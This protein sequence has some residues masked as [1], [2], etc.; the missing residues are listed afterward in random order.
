MLKKYLIFVFII[1]SFLSQAQRDKGYTSFY[2][3]GAGI[4]TQNQ[5]IFSS[6]IIGFDETLP[7]FY[8][9]KLSGFT[10]SFKYYNSE[11]FQAGL[12]YYFKPFHHYIFRNP[13]FYPILE[14]HSGFASI[15]KEKG[16]F[17]RPELAFFLNSKISQGF[18][19]KWKIGLFCDVL[20]LNGNFKQH[21][22]FSLTLM[23][24]YNR[25]FI[26]EEMN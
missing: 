17:I 5:N 23:A 25:K 19:M 1:I 14:L 18:N 13:H 15:E 4:G 24:G 22:G 8:D 16:L 9:Y 12:S 7:H 3:C 20:L 26:P 21:F 2:Y 6:F 10:A 11:G